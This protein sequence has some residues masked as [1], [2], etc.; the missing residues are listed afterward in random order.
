MQMILRSSYKTLKTSKMFTTRYEYTSRRQGHIS[1][2]LN[3]ERLLWAV[4]RNRLRH[5]ELSYSSKSKYLGVTFGS[6]VD[7][8]VQ[9]SWTKVTNAVRAQAR[10]SYA[11]NFCPAHRVQ[12]VQT[13]LLAKIWY[14][15]QVLP[16]P[17][18]HIQQLTSICTWFIWK[19]TTFRVPTTTIQRPKE[20]VGWALPDMALKCRALLLGIMW[21]LAA[22]VPATA[23]FLRKWNINDAVENLPHISK[24]PSK[25]VHVRQYALDMAYVSTPRTNETMSKL[26]SRMNGTLKAIR[27]NTERDDVMGIV[28]KYPDVDYKRLWTNLHTAWIS[29]TQWSTWYMVI[30]DLTPTHQSS[31]CNQPERDKP[32]QHLRSH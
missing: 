13:Y 12:Y 30:H 20:Q 26:R 5:W 21:T 17:T 4:G 19:C 18:R 15:A 8:T 11:C 14:M 25:L 29:D 24:I 31:G 22:Q 6:T 9:D 7:A 23:A 2:P 16:P 3:P 10:T 27:S 28:R 32:M 1:T